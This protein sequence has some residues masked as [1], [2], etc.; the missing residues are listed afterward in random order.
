MVKNRQLRE[1]QLVSIKKIDEVALK[2][3]VFVFEKASSTNL[4]PPAHATS[5]RFE[6]AFCRGL[7]F[8]TSLDILNAWREVPYLHPCDIFGDIPTCFRFPC[9]SL[10][11]SRQVFATWTIRDI[12][13]RS[14]QLVEA[15]EPA[16]P[17][18]T[19][20]YSNQLNYRSR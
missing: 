15:L 3:S 11:F 12:R 16:T 5:A 10:G 19:G 7:K 2:P 18:V 13:L 17:G 8:N 6:R 1:S 9:A 20:R 14:A 4:W